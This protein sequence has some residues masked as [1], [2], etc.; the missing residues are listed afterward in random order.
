[1]WAFADEN[2][3][4]SSVGD[5]AQLDTSICVR[6]HAIPFVALLECLLPALRASHAEV[7]CVRKIAPRLPTTVGMPDTMG[8][9]IIRTTQ[10]INDLAVGGVIRFP[11]AVAKCAGIEV[12]ATKQRRL[13]DFRQDTNDPA[14]P[15][16]LAVDFVAG[17]KLL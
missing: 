9:R 4:G 16:G 1:N 15:G 3:V 11:I 6:E 7:I 10:Q 12:N 8:D 5:R 13:F 14:P 17:G 2:G